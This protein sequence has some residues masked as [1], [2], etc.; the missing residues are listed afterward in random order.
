MTWASSVQQN[1][2]PML[3]SL[4]E[5]DNLFTGQFSQHLTPGVNYTAVRAKLSNV[6]QKYCLL[7]KTKGAVHSCE[8]KFHLEAAGIDITGRGLVYLFHLSF[9]YFKTKLNYI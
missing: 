8:S 9:Y 5:I 1:P 4:S 7:L 3:Y 6:S 2:V